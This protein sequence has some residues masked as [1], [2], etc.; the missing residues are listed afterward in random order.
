MPSHFTG[1]QTR[2]PVLDEVPSAFTPR[3]LHVAL[4]PPYFSL[5]CG[6]PCSG[7]TV[8]PWCLLGKGYADTGRAGDTTV[9]SL[10]GARDTKLHR[11]VPHW[12][13]SPCL[14]IT[15]VRSARRQ[16]LGH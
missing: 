15:S 6:V 1:T 7:W 8:S 13:L 14:L 10:P 5:H 12:M 16:S 4:L 2:Y 11:R 9:L 3:C